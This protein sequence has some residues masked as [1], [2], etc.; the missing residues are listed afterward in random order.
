MTLYVA[1]QVK[2]GREYSVTFDTSDDKTL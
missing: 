2:S 1:M